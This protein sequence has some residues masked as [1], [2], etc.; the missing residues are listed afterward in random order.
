MST[1][2]TLDDTFQG[3]NGQLVNLG[4]WMPAS[5]GSYTTAEISGGGGVTEAAIESDALYST[6]SNSLAGCLYSI[7]L[8]L[9]D[10]ILLTFTLT[11]G[12]TVDTNGLGVA[13]RWQPNQALGAPECYY[14]NL[15]PTNSQFTLTYQRGSLSVQTMWTS[16]TGAFASG[17]Y[18]I[19]VLPCNFK[20][21]VEFTRA[22]DGYYY[23]G[24]TSAWQAARAPLVE[25]CDSNLVTAGQV[26]I[27]TSC[28][29]TDANPFAI[30]SVSAGP[31]LMNSIPGQLGASRVLDRL[32]RLT[33][34]SQL[35][36][37][38]PYTYQLQRSPDGT[39]WSNLATLTPGQHYDDTTV[40]ASTAYHYRASTTDSSTTRNPRAAT[41]TFLKSDTTTQGTWI[42]VYGAAG[43]YLAPAYISQPAYGYITP[44]GLNI[45]PACYTYASSTADVRAL[46][47]PPSGSARQATVWY[48]NGSI[49]LDINIADGNVHDVS[50]YCVDWDSQGRIQ[51]VAVIDALT[52]TTLDS[53]TLSS[54]Q[55]GVYLQWAISG[56][57]VIK[58]TVTTGSSAVCSGVFVDAGSGAPSPSPTPTPTPA[59]LTSTSNVVS[60]TTPAAITLASY[61]TPTPA[62]PYAEWTNFTNPNDTTGAQAQFHMPG[63]FFDPLY[64][65]LAFLF[66]GDVATPGVYAYYSKDLLNLYP[67]PHNPIIDLTSLATSGALYR[68]HAVPMPDRYGYIGFLYNVPGTG[69][70]GY[71]FTA[72]DPMG[73][74]TRVAG[75]FTVNGHPVGDTTLFL[76]YD[77]TVWAVNA[78]QTQNTAFTPI[79]APYTSLGTTTY[80]SYT[81]QEAPAV[82]R[83]DQVITLWGSNQS[84]FSWN[85]NSASIFPSPSW[86]NVGNPGLYSATI[87][88][89]TVYPTAATDTGVW[90]TEPAGAGP[91]TFAYGY[92]G[93][94]S[95]GSYSGGTAI[96]IDPVASY[97]TQSSGI[98]ET[99]AG[100]WIAMMDRWDTNGDASSVIALMPVSWDSWGRPS[101]PAVAS[102]VPSVS[103]GPGAW[104][105]PQ[106]IWASPQGVWAPPQKTWSA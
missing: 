17:T 26:A 94:I 59:P 97:S 38:S 33:C 29:S 69:D 105:P 76:D 36:G 96:G 63:G 40:A 103:A 20:H 42:G 86:P 79:P 18:S 3:A 88:N 95:G 31:A 102:F 19:R 37:V 65:D 1:T 46:E 44:A 53:R 77:G 62:S 22:S 9:N 16:A 7:P 84:G 67:G 87:P 101:I 60:V 27:F 83:R 5:G 52:G 50:I 48:Y 28:L 47:E 61:P 30:T 71:L 35:G 8:G 85:P 25:F 55:N 6:A 11:A 4:A 75:P 66:G 100:Q 21:T 106:Q 78:S 89:S 92:G 104:T 56:H 93:A 39:T 12:N 23:N 49:G 10:P 51:T 80:V 81:G 57:V 74:W 24:L 98:I 34:L 70:T 64:G 82:V 58:L 73:P 14:L 41:A 13:W 32:V 45:G 2:N 99:P 72:T 43:Y 15:N 68:F 90:G 54:F 91:P